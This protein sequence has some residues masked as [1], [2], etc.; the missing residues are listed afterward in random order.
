MS[1]DLDTCE[2]LRM[3]LILCIEVK[4]KLIMQS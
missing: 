1:N 4:E 3:F 2:K